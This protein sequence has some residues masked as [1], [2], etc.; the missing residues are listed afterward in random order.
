VNRF[1]VAAFLSS[2]VFAS[3]AGAADYY[4]NGSIGESLSGS[5]NYFLS[6]S[7]SGST[8]KS[9]TAGNL[10]FVNRTPDTRLLLNTNFSVYD[11]FGSGAS[12]TSPKVGTP[13]GAT[14]RADHTTELN[15]YNFAASWQRE[16]VATTQLRES[17]LVTARGLLDRFNVGAGITHDLSRTDTIGLA[18][19]G[20]DVTFTGSTQTPYRNVTAVGTWNH[21]FN[22]TTALTT[23]A[24][25]DWYDADDSVNSQRLFAQ[26][27]TSLRT[28]LSQ[29]L[30]FNGSIG[31]GFSNTYQN[32]SAVLINPNGLA[33]FQS[34]PTSSVQAYVGFTYRLTKT[35]AVSLTAGHF[36][37]PTTY[38]D[39]QQISSVG[40]SLNHSINE[41]SNV[42]FAT[43]FA[44]N[45][46]GGISSDLFSA[47]V[48]YGYRLTRELVANL[49]YTYN[50][51]NDTTG[52]ANSSTVLVGLNY[53][54]TL[55]GNP[56]KQD[57]R[58]AESDR[59]RLRQRAVQAFPGLL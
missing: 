20:T 3:G 27:L 43:Q 44:H 56:T 41:F 40:L 42:S 6:N 29:R 24:T 19:N 50:Q 54:F 5:D 10:N 25:L 57:E 13:A 16:E 49:S 37:V 52:F 28:Q 35:T 31:G 14:F 30:S 18:A 59:A 12:A 36:L 17:G 4:V 21:T 22:P 46:L 58:E 33:Q 7:P 9:L 55:L 53:D 26:I 15:K 8:F 32:G 23:S 11:Y 38:G 34:G 48:G 2:G 47:Q 45:D 51:R 1:V 39:L